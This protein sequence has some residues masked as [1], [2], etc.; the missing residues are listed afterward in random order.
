M[1]PNVAAVPIPLALPAC[2]EPFPPAIVAT[3]PGMQ[4]LGVTEDD[5]DGDKSTEAE[6]EGDTEEETED[7]GVTEAIADGVGDGGALG[8][9]DTEGVA[10]VDP[11]VDGVVL[12]MTAGKSVAAAA[13]GGDDAA[14][15]GITTTA[16][17]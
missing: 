13:A 10:D 7:E 5:G 11:V 17:G 6:P 14:H 4:M 2:V 16:P 15:S 9:G 8:V 1:P 3:V 12:Q